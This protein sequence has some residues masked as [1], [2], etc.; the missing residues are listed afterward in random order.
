M[1]NIVKFEDLGHA[2]HGWLDARHHFSFANYYDK[3]RM[4]FGVLRVVNDDTIKAGAGFG[5]HPHENMEIITYVR[6]GAITHKDSMGNVGRTEAGDVQVMSAG[7]GIFH[8]EYNLES[9]ETKLYQIWIEPN[10]NGVKP[11]WDAAKFPKGEISDALPLL[12]S[13]FESSEAA[14][15]RIHQDATIHGGRLKAGTIID[16]PIRYQAYLLVSNGEVELD[17][18]KVSAGD[19]AEIVDLDK[20][21]VKANS[22]AEILIIDVPT[23]QTFN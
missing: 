8:S 18:T 7:T 17:G 14:P 16:H 20:V 15:L 22:N 11:V 21:K 13:S 6:K 9:E 12:V 5:T 2:N 4:G 3:N 1:I 23:S 19:A 10:K